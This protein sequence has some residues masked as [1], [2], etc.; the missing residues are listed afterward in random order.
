GGGLAGLFTAT[1]LVAA[2]VDD[3]M[4]VERADQPG[5]VARTVVRDGFQ[6]EPAVGAFSLPHPHLSPILTRIGAETS[7]AEGASVRQV[8]TGGR[9][10]S[11]SP[12]PK[13]LLSPIVPWSAKLRALAE[14]LVPA[15]NLEDET[16]DHFCRRRFGNRAGEMVAW[17]MAS[18]VFAGDPKRLSVRAAFSQLADL[19]RSSGS[20][21]RGVLARRKAQDPGATRPRLHY[22]SENMTALTRKAADALGERYRGG[23]GVE[24]VRKDGERWTVSGSET[25]ET[26]M[27]VLA[28]DPEQAAQ[29]VDDELAEHLR[30]V[31]RARVTVFGFGGEG[32]VLPRGFGAL[33]GPD[34]SMLT[35]GLLYESSYAPHRAPEGSWLLKA[36]AGGAPLA[37]RLTS[38]VVGSVLG[39]VQAVLGRSLDPT[40]TEV[41]NHVPGIPQYNMGHLRWLERLDSLLADRPG[42]YVTGWGY[43]GVGMTHR[44][45][46]AVRLRGVVA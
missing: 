6:L 8:Y 29:L 28:I 21:L 46:D 20:V 13:T 18:G 2:G 38:D 4:V 10:L 3:L 24:A 39:E 32:D 14:P 31:E 12:S 33:V 11:I 41:V 34:A 36:I 16:V 1:E 37:D 9:L 26:G 23:F 15:R 7:V 40:F 19:E 22:P 43:R 17:L 27:V 5:G 30:E 35:R 45:T 25:V 42:L 44:A